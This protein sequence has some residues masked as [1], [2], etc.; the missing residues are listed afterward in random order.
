MKLRFKKNIW[1]D[2][3]IIH[4]K[5]KLFKSYTSLHP[6]FK[7]F[8]TVSNIGHN[9]RLG[10]QLFQY[11]TARA[12][13]EKY[14]LPILLPNDKYNRLADFKPKCSFVKKILLENSSRYI[15]KEK[16]FSFDDAIFAEHKR[17]D[18]NGLFQTEKYFYKIRNILLK[19]LKTSEE[20]VSKYCKNYINR[21]KNKYPNKQIVALHNRRGDNVP[22]KENYSNLEL[23]VF[24]NDKNRFHPLM[25]LNYFFCAMQ[26]FDDSIFLVF[27]DTDKDIEWCKKKFKGKN[28]FF[29]EGHDDLTD[30]MLMK[31]CDHNIISN[32]SFS[33]WGAWLNE[34][35]GKKVYAP[36]V[37]FGEAYK[38]WDV[39]DLIPK[40]WIII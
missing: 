24:R 27:S 14:N 19:E 30:L 31:N 13:S 17:Y 39:S 22:S 32:S 11:A 3:K 23:G 26:M 7:S 29:S 1:I 2:K 18:I 40:E 25:K 4:F 20:N 12:Y 35:P 37:W 28:I 34:N 38:N 9:G 5:K 21:L 36:K 15:F 16:K 33:W 6:N 10:N 8:V